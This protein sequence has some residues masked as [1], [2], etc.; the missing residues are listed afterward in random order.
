[1]GKLE[2]LGEL[3]VKEGRRRSYLSAS[4]REESDA[5]HSVERREM[6]GESLLLTEEEALVCFPKKK[7]TFSCHLRL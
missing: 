3:V 7:N 4:Q 5:S 1:M 2:T 6:G